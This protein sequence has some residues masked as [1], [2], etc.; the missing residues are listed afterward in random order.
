MKNI[1]INTNLINVVNGERKPTIPITI[2]DNMINSIYEDHVNDKNVHYNNIYDCRDYYAL[3]GLIDLHVHL[4]WSGGDDPVRTMVDYG[5]TNLEALQLATCCAARALGE[6]RNIGTIERGKRADILIV[7][8]N[9]LE[10]IN[11]LRNIKM[12]ISGGEVIKEN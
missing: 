2:H 11:Y 8:G 3:P 9:P 12:I 6:E 1:I 10:D 4:L 5:A 7:E